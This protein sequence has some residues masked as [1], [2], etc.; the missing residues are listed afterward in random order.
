MLILNELI[1]I[2]FVLSNFLNDMLNLFYQ[3]LLRC[4]F[5]QNW[6]IIEILN[7]LILSTYLHI[8]LSSLNLFMQ[9]VYLEAGISEIS[10]QK[11]L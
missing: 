1:Q 11:Q 9:N 2:T 7:I 4:F 6:I 10:N 5:V 3:R 8:Q